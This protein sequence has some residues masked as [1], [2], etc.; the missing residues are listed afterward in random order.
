M[1]SGLPTYQ[2][3]ARARNHASCAAIIG[4]KSILK[5]AADMISAHAVAIGFISAKM[6]LA[7]KF[8]FPLPNHLKSN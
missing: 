6:L 2:K 8:Y 4:N 3:D 1:A 7:Q 5:A